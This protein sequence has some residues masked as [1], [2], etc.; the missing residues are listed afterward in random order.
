MGKNKKKIKKSIK[1]SRKRRKKNLQALL[2]SNSRVKGKKPDASMRDIEDRPFHE[3][4]I[5]NKNNE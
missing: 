4:L 3:N 2:K 1:E 5:K